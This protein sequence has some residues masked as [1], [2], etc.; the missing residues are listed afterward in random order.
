MLRNL[1]RCFVLSLVLVLVACSPLEQQARNTAAALQG[2]ISSA[3]AQYLSQCQATPTAA[4]PC[5]IINQAVAGQN[6][7]VTAVE[8][9]C[10]WS[11]TAP[12]ANG[13]LACTPVKGAAPGLQTA[14][15]N[16]TLF[17]T[18]IKGILKPTS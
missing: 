2:A 8:A 16:A 7:L 13:A 17:I 9:Y 3:Q 10:G 5:T 11:E 15:N 12:P 4:G 14:I 18:E 1:G 6:A